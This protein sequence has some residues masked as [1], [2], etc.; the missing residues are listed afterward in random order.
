V[1]AICPLGEIWIKNVYYQ[2]N[3]G[4]EMTYHSNK[5]SMFFV[6]AGVL[7]KLSDEVGSIVIDWE[8]INNT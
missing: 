1:V 7:G 5:L 2:I 3:K 6:E 8:C 4:K